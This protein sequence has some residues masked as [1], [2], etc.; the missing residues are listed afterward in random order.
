[1]ID[2]EQLRRYA[3]VKD[4]DDL[5]LFPLR[6]RSKTPAIDDFYSRDLTTDAHREEL[7]ALI[8]E[9]YNAA[10]RP[11]FTWCV[12]DYD[13]RND[14]DG[15]QLA[16]FKAWCLE[17]GID[18]S[19]VPQV[20]TGTG[21]IHFYFRVPAGLRPRKKLLDAKAFD[22]QGFNRRYVVAAGSIH[23]NGE[24]YRWAN[25][26]P[27]DAAPAL[28]ELL[29]ARAVRHPGGVE[30]EAGEAGCL[31]GHGVAELL[32]L[33]PP[34]EHGADYADWID[35]GMAVHH[36][37]GGAP[38]GLAAWEAWSG[39]AEGYDGSACA[40]HWES[41]S[42]EGGVTVRT[43]AH[44]ARE[45]GAE[46]PPAVARAIYNP[47][48]AEEYTPVELVV[49]PPG[50][51]VVEPDEVLGPED[52]GGD[53]GEVA[54][55]G[56]EPPRG[57]D[58]R[59]VGPEGPLWDLNDEYLIIRETKTSVAFW[60]EHAG[61]EG[62]SILRRQK[63]SD[64]S[65]WMKPR[66]FPNPWGERPPRLDLGPTWLGW[67]R[68]REYVGTILAADRGPEVLVRGGALLNL[69]RGFG[70][71]PQRGRWPMLERVLR[72]AIAAEGGFGFLVRWIAWGLQNPDLPAEVA[73][74]LRGG[75][76][77]GKGTLGNA[78][79]RIYGPHAKHLID[80]D[81]LVGRFNGW[82]EHALYVFADEAMFAGSHKAQD[83]LK[84]MVTEPT[85]LVEQ[86]FLDQRE[87]TNRLKILMA[88][89]HDWVVQAS[90]DER[91]FA[92]YNVAPTL[93]GDRA[94]WDA[95]HDELEGGGLAAFLH[96]MLALDLAG[97]HPRA[98]VPRTLGLVQQKLESLEGIEGWWYEVLQRGVPP[99][100]DSTR[101]DW[102]EGAIELDT[103]D[104]Q[105]AVRGFTKSAAARIDGNKLAQ[106]VGKKL[107]QMCPEVTRR[108]RH[109][110]G[111]FYSVPRLDVA[112]ERFEKWIGGPI[113]WDV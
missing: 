91:R 22:V 96:D 84:G 72:E 110:G 77:T 11:G 109:A 76:G 73:V 16:L 90:D 92:I 57:E 104:A 7:R 87:I 82:L 95:V 32:A 26:V 103:D 93:R 23:P 64:W 21:G 12:L 17:A 60:D 41:F 34:D 28:P 100:P 62:H 37:T 10:V 31:D 2:R 105:A 18:L 70:V 63:V 24:A 29:L 39:R 99:G 43:L 80:G 47:P 5:Y 85:Y 111:R 56:A 88:S 102:L 45:A 81:H 108:Q 42:P 52:E 113:A 9:G 36:A 3:C 58:G 75:K 49:L 83:T 20:V 46:L 15:S 61:V 19:K 1:M 59:H 107:R 48:C 86:K 97:W 40:M 54:P 14:P 6:P 71:E 44:Y 94:F 78:L 79:G 68:R 89:N 112:R 4:W 66:T 53:G 25:D 67:R 51:A 55:R 13:P 50:A 38:E 74:V 98:H 65:L 35:V 106:R 101:A 8:L 69:W 30:G 27:L 33:V